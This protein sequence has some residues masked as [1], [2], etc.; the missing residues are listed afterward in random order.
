MIPPGH[1]KFLIVVGVI[2]LTFLSLW[3]GAM[4]ETVAAELIGAALFGYMGGNVA[5][6]FSPSNGKPPTEGGPP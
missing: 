4:S 1:R 5:S 2:L 3:A 6:K